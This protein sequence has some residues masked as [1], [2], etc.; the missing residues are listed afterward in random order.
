MPAGALAIAQGDTISGGGVASG[1]TIAFGGGGSPGTGFIGTYTVSSP[2]TVA[3]ETLTATPIA[4]VGHDIC[5]C[6]GSDD[7]TITGN[8]LP[9]G[10][11]N[12][13]GPLANRRLIRGNV[14]VSDAP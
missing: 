8:S 9:D 5:V 6:A 3:S 12:D 11:Q 7:F 2:Q 1:T 13:P 10:I 4:G 14:G